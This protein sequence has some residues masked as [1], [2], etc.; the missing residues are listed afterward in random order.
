MP[1]EETFSSNC[2]MAGMPHDVKGDIPGRAYRTQRLERLEFAGKA[3]AVVF[4]AI[5][6][7]QQ[8]FE[9]LSGRMYLRGYLPHRDFDLPQL[10]GCCF[11]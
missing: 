10:Q 5:G 7:G 2:R 8:E 6:R 9:A 11:T 1:S 3:R 4:S